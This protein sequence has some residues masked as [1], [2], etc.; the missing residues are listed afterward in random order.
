MHAVRSV[1]P[2]VVLATLCP[3]LES[4]AQSVAQAAEAIVPAP[5]AAQRAADELADAQAEPIEPVSASDAER[6]P[7]E[8]GASIDPTD[9]SSAEQDR[10]ATPFDRDWLIEHAAELA[11]QKYVEPEGSRGKERLTYD[12]Y[13]AIQ[14]QR[15]ASIWARE[16]R[17]FSIDLFY[18]G[19]IYD[20]PVDINLVVGGQ[21]RRVFFTNEIFEYGPEAQRVE[22]D[23][24]HT[25]YSGF[26][27]RAPI[28]EPDV[29]DEFLAFQ[30]ASYFRALAAGQ[31]FG[32]SAR[33]LAIRTARPEGEEF[34]RFTEFWIERPRENAEELVIHALL[35]SPS[36]VGA[37]R[38]VSRPGGETTVDVEATLFPRADVASFGIAPLTSMFLFDGSTPGR[39]DDY[40]DAV[41]DS[42][43]LEIVTGGGER[44]WRPLANPRTLQVSAFVDNNP[45]GFGLVQRKRQIHDYEDY[46]TRYDQRP[47]LWV[48][49]QG[50]WGAGHVELI[51]IPTGREIH[52]NIVAY[53]QPREPLKAGVRNDLAYRLRWSSEPLD[54]ALAR[55][56][57]TRTGKSL[58]AER[59]DFVIDFRSAE[60]VPD[61]LKIEV[62]TSSGAIFNP[63]GRAVTP[64]DTY[65]VSFELEPK[66]DLE[67]LRLVLMRQDKPWSETWL[68]RW[69]R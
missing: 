32:I 58:N 39:F 23:P 43:G 46:E 40:R 5:D 41:H 53:W 22:A 51:E 27:V 25:G 8:D 61:D 34:P 67:E 7:F 19:F 17:T 20:L 65:R 3:S 69:T 6:P 38:F 21:A 18:P 57:A 28:N 29:R 47:S 64:E 44:I 45:R 48:E 60:P 12:Q 26:R 33:G 2:F 9:E 24:A 59:R 37:Y 52:D 11:K 16:N 15:A 55:V 56:Q 54:A 49:P 62:R 10:P 4:A 42:D 63:R 68:Y 14:F 13:R 30:G 36:V 66:A 31:S 1:L 35:E 50:E